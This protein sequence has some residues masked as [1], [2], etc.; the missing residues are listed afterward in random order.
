MSLQNEDSIHRLEGAW[1][2]AMCNTDTPS[3]GTQ[4]VTALE[5]MRRLSVT[6][7]REQKR[8]ARSAYKDQFRALVEAESALQSDWSDL[9]AWDNLNTAQSALEELRLSKLEAT[10][11]KSAAQWIRV[12]DRC[13]REFFKDKRK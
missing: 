10:K 11:N 9:Q 4:I 6:I 8:S 7:T 12:G 3:K 2:D 5:Q 1:Q 13:S